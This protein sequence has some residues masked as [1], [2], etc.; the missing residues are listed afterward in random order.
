MFGAISL[1]S[2]I[3]M[4]EFSSSAAAAS[5]GDSTDGTTTGVSMVCRCVF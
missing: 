3:K 1:S 4:I 2:V 5:P